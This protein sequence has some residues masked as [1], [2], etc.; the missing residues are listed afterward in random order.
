MAEIPAMTDKLRLELPNMLSEH[1]RIVE[2][3][4]RLAD[5][6]VREGNQQVAQFAEKLKLHAQTEEQ[7]LY[8]AAIVPGDYV[9]LRL[10]K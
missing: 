8:S 2:A 7:V 6:A 4:G 10:N 1:A 9:R 5:A 3:L